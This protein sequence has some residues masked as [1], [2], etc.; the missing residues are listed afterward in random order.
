[1]DYLH[2]TIEYAG[3]VMFTAVDSLDRTY[4]KAVDV[5]NAVGKPDNSYRNFLMGK[6]SEALLANG[7]QS[8]KFKIR[9][10]GFKKPVAFIP[11]DCISLYWQYQANQGNKQAQALMLS[12]V[13]AD[14]E[15]SIKESN[16][17]TVTANQHEE[18]R[19][20]IRLALIKEW[21]PQHSTLTDHRGQWTFSTQEMRNDGFSDE[22]VNITMG[23]NYQREK[24]AKLA[25]EL[26]QPNPNPKRV[27]YLPQ[28]LEWSRQVTEIDLD[29]SLTKNQ[30][31]ERI[32][33]L[34]KPS[35]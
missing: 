30:K 20:E 17:I 7:L 1:M 29:T 3:L 10:P 4:V 5:Q 19:R 16:G 28:I 12:V 18:N 22:E 23:L 32:S 34:V 27:T 9:V 33:Q 15:R 21:L 31:Q 24:E 6:S 14:L 25:Y 13:Q 11:T 26:N 2:S 35:Y 8:G